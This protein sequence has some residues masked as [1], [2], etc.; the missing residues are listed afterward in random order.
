[1]MHQEENMAKPKKKTKSGIERA[2]EA[3]GS[4]GKLAK[5]LGC[6]QQA[7]W[8]MVRRGYAPENRVVEISTLTGVPKLDLVS[9]K[10]REFVQNG[11]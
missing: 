4:Q 7:V 11:L 5:L 1:M 6:S 9:P 10:L 3:I 2:V 8:D